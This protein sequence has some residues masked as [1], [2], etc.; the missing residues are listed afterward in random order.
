VSLDFV[1]MCRS[2]LSWIPIG[3][4]ARASARAHPLPISGCRD[5][6]V[7]RSAVNA[8]HVVGRMSRPVTIS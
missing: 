7:D 6:P 5:K 2:I 4:A 1:D 3:Q 8:Q